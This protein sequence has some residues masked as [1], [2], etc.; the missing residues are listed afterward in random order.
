MAIKKSSA[1]PDQPRPSKALSA[2]RGA[3]ELDDEAWQS[4]LWHARR[5]F[6]DFEKATRTGRH[7]PLQ[8]RD[9]PPSWFE[10][11]DALGYVA[12]RVLTEGEA[13]LATPV[14][15]HFLRD[16]LPKPGGFLMP[17]GIGLAW[18]HLARRGGDP[19]VAP[20]RLSRLALRDPKGFFHAIAEDDVLALG[21]LVVEGRGAIDVRVLQALV[22]AVER[23]AIAERAPLRLFDNLVKADWISGQVKRQFC[24][25]LLAPAPDAAEVKKRAEALRDAIDADPAGEFDFPLAELE[26]IRRD[27]GRSI[28]A[29]RRHAVR[30]LVEDIGEPLRGVLAEFHLKR[31]GDQQSA[32][33][34]TLGTLDLVRSHA[35]E[36]GPDDVR[37]LVRKATR[38]TSG[39]VRQAAYRLGAEQ[40]GPDFARTALRDAFRPVRDWAEKLLARDKGTGKRAGKAGA[41]PRS[42]PAQDE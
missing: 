2:L 14:A 37:S 12:I 18:L 15:V 26:F 30:A 4:Y 38:S 9:V 40:F 31:D 36:L 1:W 17:P 35:E 25:A 33:A 10:D 13:D 42:A 6:A 19:P 20:E 11:P 34:V 41:R 32:D 21:R 22:A 24:R 7:S 23:A 8:L 39:H 5:G 28:P 27:L 16:C 3:L 29:L